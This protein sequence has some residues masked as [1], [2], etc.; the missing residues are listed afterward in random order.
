MVGGFLW[1][2]GRQQGEGYSGTMPQRSF[3]RLEVAQIV[4]AAFR[5]D[6]VETVGLA[7]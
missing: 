2:L 1:P 3:A 7:F 6:T 4:L 5:R